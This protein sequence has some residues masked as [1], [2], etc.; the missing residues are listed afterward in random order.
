M[1]T[2]F[3]SGERRTL[4]AGAQMSPM[5]LWAVH[6]GV[7]DAQ[8]Q[9]EVANAASLGRWRRFVRLLTGTK[10][11]PSLANPRLEAL[12]VQ[13]AQQ[14]L[15]NAMPHSVACEIAADQEPRAATAVALQA[16]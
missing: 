6:I 13:A 15:D 5:E 10:P 1:R 12:R 3:S 2:D 9:R 16:S 8:H 7:L 14:W 11:H 4:K